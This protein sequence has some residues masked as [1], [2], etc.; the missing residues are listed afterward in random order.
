MSMM[1][2]IVAVNHSSDYVPT[3]YRGV[4]VVI[5]IYLTVKYIK[6]STRSR[7]RCIYFLHL[8]R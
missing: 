8:D 2:F 3:G 1:K 5:D 6:N 4:Y 7:N